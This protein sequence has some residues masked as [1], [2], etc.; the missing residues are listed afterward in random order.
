[1]GSLYSQLET[2]NRFIN[3]S[4]DMFCIAGFDGFFKSL[5][6]S[7][8]NVL[9]FTTEE[10][11]A[12]PYLE[13]IH[14]EDRQATVAEAARLENREVT[15]AFENRYLCKDGSYKWFSWNAVSTP[16]QQ[17]VY[18]IAR[19]V[20]ERKRAEEALRESEERFRVLINGARDYAILMLNPSGQVASWNQGAERIKGYRADEIVGRHFSCFYPPEDVQSGKPE[21][22]LQRAIT[23][24]RYEEEGWRIR[25]DGSRFWANVVI[26]PVTDGTAQTAWIF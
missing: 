4:L 21:L 25:K 18:A 24:G 22:E 12:K 3:L 16:E 20:T 1:M 10:L 17:V 14:P 2:G 15:F 26:T 9:G 5:N 6:P 23:E 11:M 13:F 7:W 19:D 8:Q